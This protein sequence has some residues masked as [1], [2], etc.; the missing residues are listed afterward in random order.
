MVYTKKNRVVARHILVIFALLCW[1]LSPALYAQHDHSHDGHD[2]AAHD[3]HAPHD[4]EHEFDPGAT[5]FHHIGDANV[6][7]I[8]PISFPL[9][10]MAFAPDLMGKKPINTASVARFR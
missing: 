9:P 1:G 10:V 3:G 4:E 6:Y 8:G 2:H 5:A 7:S